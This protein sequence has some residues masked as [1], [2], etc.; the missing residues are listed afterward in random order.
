MVYFYF[1]SNNIFLQ[2]VNVTCDFPIRNYFYLYFYFYFYIVIKKHFE[3]EFASF[4]KRTYFLNYLPICSGYFLNYFF[5]YFLN[6]LFNYI[7]NYFLNY[8][9]FTFNLFSFIVR[10]IELF[11]SSRPISPTRPSSYGDT[12]FRPIIWL[13]FHDLLRWEAL[14]RRR[15]SSIYYYKI[16]VQQ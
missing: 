3:N 10:Y 7:L 8:L 4:S 5:N 11:F 14:L 9:L 13:I 12:C 15:C 2:S 1:Y 6:C 16:N